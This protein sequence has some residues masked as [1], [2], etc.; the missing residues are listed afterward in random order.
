M[1]PEVHGSTPARPKVARRNIRTSSADCMG[2][3]RFLYAGSKN[4]IYIDLSRLTLLSSTLYTDEL[5]RGGSAS[6]PA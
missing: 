3:F 1:T 4:G 5:Q 6:P 2:A